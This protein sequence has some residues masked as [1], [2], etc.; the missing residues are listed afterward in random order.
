MG[1]FLK[2]LRNF[3]QLFLKLNPF[4][5]LNNPSVGCPGSFG[6]YLILR[7]LDQTLVYLCYD[8]AQSV[9]LDEIKSPLFNLHR[10]YVHDTRDTS[11]SW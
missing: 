8:S 4:I 11:T 5:P 2:I 10:L 1:C 3:D 6:V 9:P 7:C